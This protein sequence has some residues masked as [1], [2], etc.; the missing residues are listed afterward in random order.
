MARSAVGAQAIIA[1]LFKIG[2]L[3][4]QV[5]LESL[6]GAHL[7]AHD[8]GLAI[9]A[10]DH[11]FTG[12]MA[13]NFA[14]VGAHGARRQHRNLQH[15]A[16]I[17]I[18]HDVG[19]GGHQRGHA[20]IAW[21]RRCRRGLAER[22][23]IAGAG[24][25]AVHAHQRPAFAIPAFDRDGLILDARAATY[26]GGGAIKGDAGRIRGASIGD[27]R[28]SQWFQPQIVRRGSRQQH[29]GQHWHDK[30]S[31]APFHWLIR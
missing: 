4:Q 20:V 31:K 22:L 1:D 17:A 23:Q 26:G 19:R 25:F 10:G 18:H 8:I 13:G 6:P 11:R 27:D 2:D 24:R 12:K 3:D 9:V 14:R 16:A 7:Q 28:F 5:Q 29:A 30:Q 15:F 21:H